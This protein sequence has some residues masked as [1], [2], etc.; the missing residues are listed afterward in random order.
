MRELRREEIGDRRARLLVNQEHRYTVTIE[1]RG[2]HGTWEDMSMVA[3][4]DLPLHTAGLGRTCTASSFNLTITRCQ[5]NCYLPCW[6]YK[7]F[8]GSLPISCKCLPL[9]F[10]KKIGWRLYRIQSADINLSR[11]LPHY[12]PTLP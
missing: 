4:R 8:N 9:L 11:P 1:V 7:I 2:P 6:Q 3:D 12:S 5:Q 10:W